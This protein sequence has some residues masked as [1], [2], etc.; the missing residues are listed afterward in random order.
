MMSEKGS[1]NKKKV[2]KKCVFKMQL[3]HAYGLRW[4]GLNACLALGA[5]FLVYDG[6]FFIIQS[7]GLLRAL[8]D[9]GSTAY[10]FLS[11]NNCRH[12]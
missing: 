12:Y 7:D 11:V 2:A 6:Y 9:T 1:A 4:A 10:A 5:L 3:L 8:L